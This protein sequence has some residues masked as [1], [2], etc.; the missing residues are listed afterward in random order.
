MCFEKL[1]KK[2]IK[3]ITIYDIALIKFAVLLGTL[4]LISIF[5]R[6]LNVVL[7]I[8]PWIYLGAMIIVAIPVWK[9]MF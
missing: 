1:T 2:L 5:P 7:A 3:N 8:N 6:L 4:F 9:K